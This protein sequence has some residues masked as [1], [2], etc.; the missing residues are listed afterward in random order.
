M[1]CEADRLAMSR[2]TMTSGIDLAQIA[3]ARR[4]MAELADSMPEPAAPAVLLPWRTAVLAGM[5][6]GALVWV[7]NP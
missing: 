5:L 1:I 3:E 6:V 4:A 2:G 7:I